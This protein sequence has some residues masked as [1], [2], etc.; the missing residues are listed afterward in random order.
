VL[1]RQTGADSDTRTGTALWCCLSR[2]WEPAETS[3]SGART[4]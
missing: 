4:D 1:G 2:W 3:D